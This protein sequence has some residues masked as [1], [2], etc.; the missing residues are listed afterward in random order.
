MSSAWARSGNRKCAER[1]EE[2]LKDFEDK[3]RAGELEEPPGLVTYNSVLLCL[4]QAKE[5]ERAEAL[6]RKML[7]MQNPCGKD[8]RPDIIS[9]NTCVNAFARAGDPRKAEEILESMYKEYTKTHDASIAPTVET[10]STV[11]TAWLKSKEP[12]AAE[13]AEAILRTMQKLHKAG[14][15]E[16]EPNSIAFNIVLTAWFQS[17]DR[18]APRRAEM[19]LTEME[20][21]YDAGSKVVKPD[22]MAYE[23]CIE[24]YANRR[25]ARKAEDVLERR[26]TQS[27]SA[28][29]GGGGNLHAKPTLRSYNKVLGSYKRDINK[30]A[31]QRADS[32][33]RRLLERHDAGIVDFPPDSLSVQLVLEAWYNAASYDRAAGKRA[34]SFVQDLQKSKSSPMISMGSEAHNKL[35]EIFVKLIDAESAD[36]YFRKVCN[37]SIQQKESASLKL[38]VS[39]LNKV[40]GVWRKSNSK[41]A[42]ERIEA[43]LTLVKE[44]PQLGI[45]PNL[46]SYKIFLNC[47]E[48]NPSLWSAS[49]A[50]A[51]LEEMEKIASVEA[52]KPNAQDYTQILRIWSKI[53][54]KSSYKHAEQVFQ[55]MKDQF[56]AGH[57]HCTPTIASYHALINC[58]SVSE[59]ADANERIRQLRAQMAEIKHQRESTR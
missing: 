15:L 1:A 21:L 32:L 3:Y 24:G 50:D 4:S 22:A 42:G 37:D 38:D 25:N 9:F 56:D 40:L 17:N 12:T 36:E 53:K 57:V 45:Q 46:A 55:K 23:H 59:E 44:N 49:Q 18:Y 48:D 43:L 29:H 28:A 51:T 10:F 52:K 41:E 27:L 34:R 54:D 16:V 30:D 2:I 14:I 33:C 13:R 11:L 58:W 47:L 31:A 5:G 19:L 8:V 20:D 6:I 26:H 39:S 35:I 7:E